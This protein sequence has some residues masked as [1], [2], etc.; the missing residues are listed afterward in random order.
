MSPP[1]ALSDRTVEVLTAATMA[2][3]TGTDPFSGGFL[4]EHA[5]TLDE[6][7]R[8]AELLAMGARLLVATMRMAT[9]AGTDKRLAAL[10]L[11]EAGR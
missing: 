1:S 4:A 11:S 3:E 9:G 8:L 7:H 6:C 5:V 2:L 10:M